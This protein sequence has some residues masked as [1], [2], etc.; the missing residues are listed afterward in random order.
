METDLS[1][2]DHGPAMMSVYAAARFKVFQRGIEVILDPWPTELN[3][4]D[5]DCQ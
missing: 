4:K 5:Q 3:Q 1:C 2:H